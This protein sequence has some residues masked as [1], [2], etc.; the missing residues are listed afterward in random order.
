[1]QPMQDPNPRAVLLKD[2]APPACLIESVDLHFE[3]G[4]EVTLVISQLAVRRNPAAMAPE[5][6]LQLFGRDLG[7]RRLTLNDRELTAGEYLISGETL[8]I[9]GVPDQFTLRVETEIRPQD[10]TSL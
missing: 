10:N 6:S 9:P 5:R 7:L 4:E 1:M 2:Y 3:L 8:R